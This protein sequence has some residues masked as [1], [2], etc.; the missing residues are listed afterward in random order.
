MNVCVYFKQ[1]LD[2]DRI[3]NATRLKPA[4]MEGVHHHVNAASMLSAMSST[5]NPTANACKDT[6]ETHPW[7]AE[8]QRTLVFP[9][10]V[11]STQCVKST[12]EIQ[13]ASALKV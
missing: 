6:P 1:L 8:D 4:S 7:D 10:L 3:A 2:V 11:E 9:T 5:I 12:M 13:Y